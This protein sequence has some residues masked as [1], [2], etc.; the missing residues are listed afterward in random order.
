M[1]FMQA[2]PLVI[3]MSGASGFVGSKL[4]QVFEKNGWQVVTLGRAEF[5]L[6]VEGLARLLRGANCIVNLAGAPVFCRW[7][8]A[9]KKVMVQSRVALT[10]KLV[11]ACALLDTPPQVF[12]SASAVGC[13]T[14]SGTHSEKTHSLA[15]D[16]LGNLVRDWEYEAFM[17]QGLGIRT[18]V[19]RFGAVL[20]PGG[21]ALTKMLVP[22]RLGLG[23]RIG[24]G[25][26]SF[27]WVHLHDLARVFEQ[28]LQDGSFEGVYNL[29]A[30]F[31]TT[32]AGLTQALS[33][34]LAR[35]AILPVP[36]F[37]LRILFGEAAQ[38]L[39]SGQAVLPQRLLDRGFHFDF[40]TIDA[41]VADCV[42][43]S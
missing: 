33:R 31:P 16:F 40:P 22:F 19:F 3:A 37:V 26:Q 25:K 34:A 11:T 35:P 1:E 9:Y 4:R 15:N 42:V 7:S 13:Y 23:G 24:S 21:G 18:A 39:T 8:E 41:A 12:L 36:E 17:A 2:C 38:V 28:A 43:R 14:S 10:R 32:N 5:A 30:P 6:S 29:T 20:G 27:S